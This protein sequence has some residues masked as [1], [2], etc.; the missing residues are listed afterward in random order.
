MPVDVNEKLLRMQ[1]ERLT[2]YM[3]R[4]GPTADCLPI[5]KPTSTIISTVADALVKEQQC[6]YFG[7]VDVPLFVNE[8]LNW[9]SDSYCYTAYFTDAPPAGLL[10]F[11]KHA[12][13]PSP[14]PVITDGELIRPG[15]SRTVYLVVNGTLHAFPDLHTFIAYGRDFSEVQVLPDYLF[16]HQIFFGADL[17][18]L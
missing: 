18:P 13:L 3:S 6:P 2:R 5:Y 8:T 14:A 9:F 11:E 12:Q 1:W 17:P 7:C 16:G 4:T 10:D 15:S